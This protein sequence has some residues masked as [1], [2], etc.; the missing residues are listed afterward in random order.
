MDITKM[1]YDI[2]VRAYTR[3]LVEEEVRKSVDKS[4]PKWPDYVLVFD[5]EAVSPQI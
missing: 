3:L 2:Y 5:C 4:N 1:K